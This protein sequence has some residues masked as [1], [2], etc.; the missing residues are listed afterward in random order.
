MIKSTKRILLSLMAVIFLLAACAPPPQPTPEPVDIES[1]VATA[2]AL[3]V[4]AQ[5]TQTAAAIPPATNTP[6]PTQTKAVAPSPTTVLA[7]ATALVLPTATS[8]GG[9]GS[10]GSTT[11]PEYAC[12]VV[13]RTP[14][15][16]TVFL[17]N[18][19]FDISWT[20]QNTG[21]KTMQAG[22][23][24]KFHDG[25]LLATTS[26]AELPELKPGAQYTVDFDGVAPKK[27]G[28]HVMTFIVEGGLCYPYVVI[29]V[30]K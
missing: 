26:R 30:E 6:L 20:I 11:K 19:T 4:A 23:D 17:P 9:G 16:N 7:T 15:D 1:Q 29:K 3:T 18:K 27:E 10:G 14:A 22:L 28:F 24:V 2:V 5:N 21:T 12:A 25:T 8:G 13:R